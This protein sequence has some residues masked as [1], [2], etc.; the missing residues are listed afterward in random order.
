[1]TRRDSSGG[2]PIR[3]RADPATGAVACIRGLSGPAGGAGESVAICE[4]IGDPAL[5]KGL[6]ERKVVHIVTP[7]TVTDEALLDE[8]R[9]TLLMAISRSKQGYGLDWA[10]LAG[11][12]SLVD[13]VDN[14]DAP[15]AEAALQTSP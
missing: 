5:A 14:E 6:I 3:R 4:Q 13:E 15:E 2:A 10:D 9:D 11:R 12:R 1:M 8:R 7:G